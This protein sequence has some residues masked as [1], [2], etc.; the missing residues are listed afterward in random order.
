MFRQAE[1][2]LKWMLTISLLFHIT[3]LSIIFSSGILRRA[4]LSAAKFSPL[5]SIQISIVNLPKENPGR[6]TVPEPEISKVVKSTATVKKTEKKKSA[7]IEKKEDISS[8]KRIEKLREVI[9]SGIKKQ[10]EAIATPV[11]PAGDSAEERVGGPGE[12][13]SQTASKLS[14]SGQMASGPVVDLPSFKYDYYLGL[15]KNKVDNRW[16][17]PV[18]HSNTRKALIEFTINRKGDV[19][20][21]KVADSSGDRYFDQT[22]MRA[23]TLSTPFPPLPRGYKGDSLKVHY[24]FIFGEKG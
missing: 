4:D 13:Q 19:S 14:G 17:Q 8:L 1:T 24:R 18:T 16:S 23:V 11:K 20:N 21:V 5:S 7:V 2:N 15:I 22:A 12:V 10:K 3:I 6:M 9:E